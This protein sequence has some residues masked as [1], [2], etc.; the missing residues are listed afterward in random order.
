MFDKSKS[1]KDCPDRTI[2]PPRC[3]I[4]CKEYLERVEK[5]HKMMESIR[6]EKDKESAY[7]DVRNHHCRHR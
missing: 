5:R 2:G 7:R 3:H 6:E 4:Y 1:C